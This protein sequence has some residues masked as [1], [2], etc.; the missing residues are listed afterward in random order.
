LGIKLDK[1]NVRKD[2]TQSE[3]INSTQK[4]NHD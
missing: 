4:E 1:V 2:R 3:S